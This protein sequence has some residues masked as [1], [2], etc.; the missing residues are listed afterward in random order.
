ML[1]AVVGGMLWGCCT[2]ADCVGD[3]PVPLLTFNY[4]APPQPNI[5][6][7]FERILP[8]NPTQKD[9]MLLMFGIPTIGTYSKT[10]DYYFGRNNFFQPGYSYII[11]NEKYNFRDTLHQLSYFVRKEKEG[12]NKYMLTNTHCS[13]Y[14]QYHLENISFTF[15]GRLVQGGMIPD[16]LILK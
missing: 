11:I 16:T 12:C 2:K 14:D 4:K 1:F 7:K 6:I 3:M 9:S 5:K 10:F 13:Y 15:H 8:D